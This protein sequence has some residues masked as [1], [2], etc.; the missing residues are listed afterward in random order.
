[1]AKEYEILRSG[2]DK[3]DRHIEIDNVDAFL[4]GGM[5]M[6]SDYINNDVD[7]FAHDKLRS[8]I[9]IPSY[10]VNGKVIIDDRVDK[11]RMIKALGFKDM[12]TLHML[13]PTKIIRQNSNKNNKI[14]TVVFW[15][16]GT[17]T[18]VRLGNNDNDDVET[19]FAYALMKRV[20]GSH[21]GIQKMIEKITTE[22]GA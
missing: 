21:H 13:T 4:N 20:F 15:N 19:A 3:N 9:E 17:K 6:Y 14:S 22:K 5:S 7:M 2:I 8:T 10:N 18:I 16:D 1:M 12:Y 11:E